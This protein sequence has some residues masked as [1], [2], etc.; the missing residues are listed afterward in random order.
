[1]Y[2]FKKR[3]FVYITIILL[4]YFFNVEVFDYT[5]KENDRYQMKISENDVITFRG[6]IV[7]TDQTPQ[8]FK[9]TTGKYTY[10]NG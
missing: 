2:K 9:L 7:A 4:Y 10:F 8:Q 5:F 6:K 3:D 1:M